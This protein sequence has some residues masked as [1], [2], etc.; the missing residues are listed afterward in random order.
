MAKNIKAIKC[1]NCGSVKKTEIKPDYFVCKSCDTEYFLDND[2]INVNINHTPNPSAPVPPI[3]LKK[4]VPF[5][6]GGFLI[7]SV[8]ILFRLF[9][10]SGNS[11]RTNFTAE[12]EKYDFTT[13]KDFVYANSTTK[14]AVLLRIGRENIREEN[15][16]YDFVNTHAVFIDPISKTTIKDDLLFNRTRRLD[17]HEVRFYSGT[18]E[19]IYVIHTGPFIYNLNRDNN[20]LVDV[21]NTIFKKHPELA[22]GVAKIDS[23]QTNA[24]W[25]VLSNDGLSYYYYPIED[26]LTQDYNVVRGMERKSKIAKPFKIDK[27]SLLKVVAVGERGEEET[28]TLSE[29]KKL[30]DGKI[31]YQ[32]QTNLII[33]TKSNANSE[34]LNMLQSIDVNTGKTLWSLPANNLDYRNMCRVKEGYAIRYSSNSKADYVFGVFIISPDGKLLHDYVILRNQ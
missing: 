11:E 23:Y 4:R 20:Q 3:E 34:S 9:S 32:D 15:G 30:F 21:T 22:A 5:I 29:N 2:D 6:I 18:D 33:S 19:S 10:P 1:P 27:H 12:K 7:L 14:K 24:Y 28:A 25:T 17:N 31:N 26:I 8:I 16:N 13:S